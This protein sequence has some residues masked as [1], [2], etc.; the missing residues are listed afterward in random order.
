MRGRLIQ[1]MVCV[2]RRLDPAATAAVPGGGYDPVFGEPIPVHDGTQLGSP[3]RREEAALRLLCQLDRDPR[4][5][6][7]L[8]TRGGH[9]EQDTLVIVLFMEQLE[10]MG[11]LGADGKPEIQSGDRIEAIEDRNGNPLVTF[12]DPPG[13]YVHEAA[14]QGYGL[15][16]FKTPKINLFTL[17]CRP[18]MKGELE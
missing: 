13:M 4:L 6:V 18:E 7:D 3:S 10:N 14:L 17:T 15:A 5:G 1:K 12:P 11:L 2:L 8:M 16:A 9:Q